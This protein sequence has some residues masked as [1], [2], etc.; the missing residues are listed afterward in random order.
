ML[1]H[2]IE[3]VLASNNIAEKMYR[4]KKEKFIKVKRDVGMA[5][6]KEERI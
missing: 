5:C 3:A 6:Q 2:L 4:K 1:L